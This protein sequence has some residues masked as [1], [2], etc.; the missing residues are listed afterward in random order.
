MTPLPRQQRRIR[1]ARRGAHIVEMA[2]VL[3]ILIMIV[4]GIIEFSRANQI[5]QTVKQAAYEGARAGITMDATVANVQAQANSVLSSVGI[6]GS[7]VTVSPN[8]ITSS[9]S[10]VTVTVSTSATA[11][12][13]FMKYFTAGQPISAAVTL[14]SENSGI[15]FMGGS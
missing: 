14:E 12:G 6:T 10:F 2:L 5:R 9:T 1:L 11:N 7:T 8:P 13:W 3:P 4:F 15:S